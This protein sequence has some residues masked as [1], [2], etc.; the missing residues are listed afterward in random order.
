MFLEYS[1]PFF[2][3]SFLDPISKLDLKH[4]AQSCWSF[5]GL[6][7]GLF[8]N[9]FLE[10]KSF[11]LFL[12]FFQSWIKWYL[13]RPILAKFQLNIQHFMIF[14]NLYDIFGLFLKLLMAKGPGNPDPSFVCYKMRVKSRIYSFAEIF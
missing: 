12:A 14:Q 1:I 7:F 4:T 5:S 10:I 8:W 2:C 13:F 11:G 9:S 3:L 6:P